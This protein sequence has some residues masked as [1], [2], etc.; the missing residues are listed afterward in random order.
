MSGRFWASKF[1]D[2]YF[3]RGD[4]RFYGRYPAPG[5]LHHSGLA[6]RLLIYPPE[7]GCH[8]H[9]QRFLLRKLVKATHW[10]GPDRTMIATRRR[11]RLWRGLR[12]AAGVHTIISKDSN[13]GPPPPG[14]VCFTGIGTYPAL[15]HGGHL[16]VR[17]TLVGSSGLTVDVCCKFL[18]LC[19]DGVHVL[20]TC[21][22]FLSHGLSLSV[23]VSQASLPHSISFIAV[24]IVVLVYD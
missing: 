9:H 5:G 11:L 3:P 7:G 13:S 24:L 4:G 19:T 18:A 2:P 21:T 12:R 6:Y 16:W 1:L 8:S 20:C 10:L 14:R 15:W 17:G 23:S 22:D